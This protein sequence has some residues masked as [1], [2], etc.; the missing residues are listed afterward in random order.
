[1]GELIW[2]EKGNE[3]GEGEVRGEKQSKPKKVFL[4]LT[5]KKFIVL[6]GRGKGCEPDKSEPLEEHSSETIQ[7]RRA[8]S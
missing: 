5:V 2:G 7:R 1:L 6:L 8:W 4:E 3:F